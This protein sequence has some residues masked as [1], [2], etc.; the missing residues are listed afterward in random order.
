MAT[1]PERP[2]D[3]ALC[4]AGHLWPMETDC[5]IGGRPGR[6]P[7]TLELR[8]GTSTTITSHTSQG[9][10]SQMIPCSLQ[11]Q[12]LAPKGP[13]VC[14]ESR[15]IFTYSRGPGCFLVYLVCCHSQAHGRSI[16]TEGSQSSPRCG[17]KCPGPLLPHAAPSH[18]PQSA[19]THLPHCECQ[20]RLHPVRPG[21]FSL[22]LKTFRG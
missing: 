22:L 12:H 21:L 7:F 1:F 9:L 3:E 17:W 15:Y 19:V 18:T 2:W 10:R 8:P 4:R 5:S 13:G 20:A 16:L 6:A 11:S 14:W